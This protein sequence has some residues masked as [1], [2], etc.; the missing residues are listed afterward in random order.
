MNRKGEMSVR[1]HDITLSRDFSPEELRR[2]AFEAGRFSSD[3]V[4]K[5]DGGAS[6]IDMKSLLGLLLLSLRKGTRITLQTKGS[7]EEEAIHAIC[8]LLEE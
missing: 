7:D 1:V 4:L 5:F 3:I 8:A 2:I 6:V